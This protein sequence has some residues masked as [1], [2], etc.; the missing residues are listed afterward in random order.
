MDTTI[1]II[2]VL[3]LCAI[4]LFTEKINRSE[5]MTQY[6][7][8]INY[9]GDYIDQIPIF[10]INL[11]AR[12]NK[13]KKTMAELKKHEL[14]GTFI[15][16][17]DGR[18]LDV[19]DLKKRGIIQE[20]PDYRPLRRGEIG[21]YLSHLKCWN[22]ILKTEKPYGLVLEDDVVFTDNFREKFN[23]IFHHIK[24]MS[25]DIIGLGRRCKQNWFDKDCYAG[26]FIYKDAFYPSVVGYGAFAYIIKPETIKKLLKTTFPIYKPI[27]VVILEEQE[28][29]NIKVIS[30]LN[31]LITVFDIIHSDTIGI[32]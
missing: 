14:T 21:C 24:D 26:T 32:K 27:D 18:Y 6:I 7:D 15:E 30:L 11:K 19:D 29:G 2:I 12:P 4:Y 13:K 25:W 17:L 31:D 1:L 10:I 5:Y 9:N 3:I 8:K 22:L 28:K 20:G 16:A 23:D